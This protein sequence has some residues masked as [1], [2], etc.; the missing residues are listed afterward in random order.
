MGFRSGQYAKSL[1]QEGFDVRNLSGSIVSWTH[2]NYPLV[3]GPDPGTATKKVSGALQGRCCY[4]SVK[5]ACN[6]SISLYSNTAFCCCIAGACV[7]RPVE[8]AGQRL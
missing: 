7:R 5:N 3:T 1:R 6:S 4:P 2:E 8:A